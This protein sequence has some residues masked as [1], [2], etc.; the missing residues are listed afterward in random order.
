M[1]YTC[2]QFCPQGGGGGAIPACIAGGIPACLAAGLG[3]GYPS[4]PCRFPGPHPGGKLRGF[5]PG[6]SPDPHPGGPPGPH[7]GGMSIPACTEADPPTAAAAGGTHPTGMHS[8]FYDIFRENKR[9]ISQG[10]SRARTNLVISL[11]FALFQCS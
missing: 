11:S 5:W 10:K 7:P 4:M 3:G 6:G 9:A 8:C 1:F 2:L